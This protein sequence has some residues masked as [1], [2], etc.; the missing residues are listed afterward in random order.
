MFKKLKPKE[1]SYY[2]ADRY[3]GFRPIC[4]RGK[5]QDVLN[6]ANNLNGTDLKDIMDFKRQRYVIL[7]ADYKI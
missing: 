6:I 7:L 2:V 4:L 5:K 3:N 1:L